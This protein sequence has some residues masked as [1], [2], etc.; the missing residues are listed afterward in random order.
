MEYGVGVRS[1]EFEISLIDKPL[2]TQTQNS[3]SKL[4]PYF[5][6][7]WQGMVVFWLLVGKVETRVKL[8]G[9]EGV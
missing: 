9:E 3:N 6:P 2:P 4:T 1:W 7:I 5:H 8:K